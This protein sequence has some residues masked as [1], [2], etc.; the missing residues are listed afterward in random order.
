MGAEFNIFSIAGA[1]ARHAA[2]RQTIIAKNVA[3]A[4]TPGF[5]A[6]DLE[7][8][9]KALARAET[10]HGVEAPRAKMIESLGAAA[11]NG[12][13]VSLEDQMMRA[14]QAVRDHD[15]ATTI[16]AKSIAMLRAALGK[17]R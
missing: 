6:R 4:D 10:L 14:S 8:F 13:T 7:P 5:L 2:G 3:N 12:N 11:P 17:S 9:D 15:I 16:Y 1:M